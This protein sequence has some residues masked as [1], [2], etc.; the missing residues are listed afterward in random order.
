M[1]DPWISGFFGD[2]EGNVLIYG[3]F[4]FSV[5]G[6]DYATVAKYSIR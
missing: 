5:D 6:F 4:T 2:I 1:M 3:D